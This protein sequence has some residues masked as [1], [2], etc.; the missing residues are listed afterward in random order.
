[1]RRAPGW[2]N[3]GP[4]VTTRAGWTPSINEVTLAPRKPMTF[5]APS[6]VTSDGVSASNVRDVRIWCSK[7][8]T[9]TE[10]ARR[11][12]DNWVLRRVATFERPSWLSGRTGLGATARVASQDGSS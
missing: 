1:M 9:M 4:V 2:V 7:G 3:S 11:P 12:P 6:V 10:R 5:P 8:S